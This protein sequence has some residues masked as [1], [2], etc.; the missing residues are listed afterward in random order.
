M[1]ATRIQEEVVEYLK[2]AHAFE[3]DV[4]HWL[5]L[6]IDQTR[7]PEIAHRLREHRE[8]NE[9]HVRSLRDRLE[10]LGEQPSPV[11]Q[12][13]FMVA[14]W[15]KDIPYRLCSDKTA[16]NGRDIYITEAM[17]IAAWSL[18]E[19]LAMRAG[20]AETAELAR[21]NRADEEAMSDFV[22]RRWDR[23]VELWLEEDEQ[24]ATG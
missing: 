7:D 18:L 24:A 13:T 23:F 11:K 14:S 12:A 22:R 17:E 5:D 2:I 16:K 19:A 20:D 3:R 21:R 9:G 1:T 6:V 15:V 8:E 4:C 10:A